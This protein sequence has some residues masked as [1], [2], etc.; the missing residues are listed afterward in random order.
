MTLTEIIFRFLVGG[1][2][3]SL[4]AVIGQVFKPRTFGGLF[5]AAPSVALATLGFTHDKHGTEYVL[6]ECRSMI[7]GALAF[8]VYGAACVVLSKRENFPEWLA[9]GASWLA[10]GTAAAASIGVMRLT[11]IL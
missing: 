8:T 4:F 11:G 7:A 2:L 1:A 3:V 5:G 10:W 6:T 9:A